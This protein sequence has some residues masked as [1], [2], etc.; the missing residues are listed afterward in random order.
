VG[1]RAVDRLSLT[2]GAGERVVLLGPSGCGKTTTLR[3]V[4]GLETPDAGRVRLDGVDTTDW[5]PHRRDVALVFQDASL[6]PHLDVRGNLAFGPRLRKWKK[7][8]IDDGVE[9]VARRLG[10]ADLLA[11][12]PEHL[13]GGERRR[14]ALGRALVRRPRVLLLDEPL[15]GLDA[16]ARLE[17][18]AELVRLHREEPAMTLHVTHDQEEALALGDRLA[19]LREGCIVQVGTPGEV[20]DHPADTFVARFVGSPPMN[21]LRRTRDGVECLMGVRPRE[22][23]LTAGKEDADMTAIIESVQSLGHESHV[24]LGGE[25]SL[26]VVVAGPRGLQVGDRV[27][28]TFVAEAQ[29][30]FDA[31]TGMRLG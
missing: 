28:L 6:Y 26:T 13:S 19:V 20:H 23:R 24:I 10:I 1:A 16:P 15:S 31:A 8:E 4:A 9:R 3:L 29:H 7:K 25:E 18:R 21:L 14:V 11:R 27:G 30:W 5:P 22:V 12:K 2:V 17:L